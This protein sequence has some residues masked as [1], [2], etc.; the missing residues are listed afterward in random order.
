MSKTF[1]DWEEGLY[2]AHYGVPGMRKGV[3]R[4]PELYRRRQQMMAAQRQQHGDSG[5][6]RDASS[7]TRG[8]SAQ[9]ESARRQHEAQM[10][11]QHGPDQSSIEQAIARA[12]A[13]GEKRAQAQ[14]A[15]RQKTAAA[16]AQQEAQK[17]RSQIRTGGNRVMKR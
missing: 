6:I 8:G 15:E 3:H 12:K 9:D 13:E 11:A 5:V 1:T 17:K 7:I 14:I 2:L 10:R 16:Q 4:D